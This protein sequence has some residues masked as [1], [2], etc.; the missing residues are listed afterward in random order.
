MDSKDIREVV[1]D[2]CKEMQFIYDNYDDL[3]N[4]ENER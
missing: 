1:E 3:F 2:Y 4:T